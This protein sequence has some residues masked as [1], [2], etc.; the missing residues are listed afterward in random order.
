MAGGLALFIIVLNPH[1]GDAEHVPVGLA[2]ISTGATAVGIAAM[3]VAGRAARSLRVRTALYGAA[4]GSGF[5]LTASLIK[6]AVTHLSAN[7]AAALFETWET[8]GLAVSGVASVVLVQAA[9]HTGTLV[10]A[11]PG[12]TLFDP[13]VAVLWGTVVLDEST[14]TGP[15]LLLAVVGFGIIVAAVFALARPAA[16]QDLEATS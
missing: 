1:G 6:V 15:V 11:Q 12:I 8:Y 7:G 10:D 13:L 2:L 4:A 3:V 5:G 14:S 16:L 9:L